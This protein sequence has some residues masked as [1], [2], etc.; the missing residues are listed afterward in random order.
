MRRVRQHIK[1]AEYW[2]SGNGLFTDVL[3][4]CAEI[5]QQSGLTMTPQDAFRWLSHG[6][7]EDIPGQFVLGGLGLSGVKSVQQRFS[8]VDSEES[9]AYLADGMNTFD[10]DL[11]DAVVSWMGL[12]IH[13][14][15]DRI[16]VLTRGAS[17]LPK[18][19][20]YQMV[21]EVLQQHRTVE[22]ILRTLQGTIAKS[23]PDHSSRK[24]ALQQSIFCLESMISQGWVRASHT[25]G[26]P[27]LSLRT[28]V[29]GEIV[30]TE[31]LGPSALR[32]PPR[33]SHEH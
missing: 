33:S 3:N 13:G 15:I 2:Y 24:V 23:I 11:R 9:V 1:F 17:R 20:L 30:Y 31:K 25:P 27:S 18:T 19:G 26:M 21:F 14:R 22:P 4:N 5:A 29:E 10:L 28:P 8:H 7:V 6:G 12:P 16:E 32:P